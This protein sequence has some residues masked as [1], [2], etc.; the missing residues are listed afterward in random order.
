MRAAVVD[1]SPTLD[2]SRSPGNPNL[3]RS[4]ETVQ[5]VLGATGVALPRRYADVSGPPVVKAAGDG[6]SNDPETNPNDNSYGVVSATP[7]QAVLCPFADAS[8]FT[9]AY[10]P[11]GR[12]AAVG[13]VTAIWSVQS[14]VVGA[15]VG[16]IS[17]ATGDR[18]IDP[19]HIWGHVSAGARAHRLDLAGITRLLAMSDFFERYIKNEF[20]PAPDGAHRPYSF[21]LSGAFYGLLVELGVPRNQLGYD[22]RDPITA[23]DNLGQPVLA[24]KRLAEATGNR[25]YA[26][27]ISG[28]VLLNR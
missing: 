17:S 26:S 2:F 20:G 9:F 1:L 18:D 5:G 7:G 22:H 19:A 24:S 21:D 6:Y 16:A 27:G 3:A 8:A 14:K 11:P 28:V 4:Y 13:A 25:S 15:L 12:E 10:A 23:R